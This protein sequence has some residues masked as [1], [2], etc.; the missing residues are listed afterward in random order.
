M[1]GLKQRLS[2]GDISVLLRR[3]RGSG[4]HRPLGPSKS[5]PVKAP[6]VDKVVKDTIGAI[7]ESEKE[8][9]FAARE[10]EHII[11][12]ER[13]AIEAFEK[14]SSG[15]GGVGTIRGWFNLKRET[16]KNHQAAIEEMR[17]A[18]DKMR[19][20]EQKVAAIGERMEEEEERLAERARELRRKSTGVFQFVTDNRAMITKAENARVS[21][22]G[23]LRICQ[24]TSL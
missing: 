5:C 20:A 23:E 24:V 19:L 8:V 18:T 9:E 21:E 12:R 11:R 13:R 22:D 17:R 7:A 14:R 6:P 15:S 2:E 10:M 3:S 1:V 4:G 16:D